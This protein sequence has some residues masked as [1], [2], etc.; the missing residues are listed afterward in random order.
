MLDLMDFINLYKKVAKD[1]VDETG[2]YEDLR[3]EHIVNYDVNYKTHEFRVKMDDTE[4]IF[5]SATVHES[6]SHSV[7][8]W[9]IR[10]FL[11]GVMVDV[12]SG[13]TDDETALDILF[14]DK[15]KVSSV[16]LRSEVDNSI[17]LYINRLMSA[18]MRF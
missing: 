1:A 4:V 18:G 13:D 15:A 7:F 14:Y 12:D 10:G 9:Q 6:A 11:A 17:R 2:K 8:K 5:I 16:S 3:C